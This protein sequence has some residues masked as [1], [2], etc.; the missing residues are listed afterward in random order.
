M[1]TAVETGNHK[2]WQAALPEVQLAI[3][4]TMSRT[5]KASP[6]ELFIGKV[7]RPLQLM[8]L[9]TDERNV[10]LDSVREH[11]AQEIETNAVIEKARF[12]EKKAKVRNFKEGDYVLL[13]NHERNKTKLEPKFK[14]PY[15]VAEVLEGD[16]YLLKALNSNRMYKYAHDRIRP[17]PECYVPSELN[18]GLEEPT[19]NEE[20]ECAD[21]G[22]GE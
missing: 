14:G 19:N 21:N 7:A 12:D 15:Q 3:N 17:V 11:A 10:D 16:M 1:L 20:S 13:E 2:S 8:T 4:C 9:D 22:A 6:P 18:V 5:T